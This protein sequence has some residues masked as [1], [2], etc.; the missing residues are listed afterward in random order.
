MLALLYGS[1][2]NL[3]VREIVDAIE[4]SNA[5]QFRTSVLKPAHKAK[6]IDFDV[7][8]DSVVLSPLGARYVEQKVP[9]TI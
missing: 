6:L 1:A 8:A 9:L 2:G 7:K 4:Y 3:G 5:S